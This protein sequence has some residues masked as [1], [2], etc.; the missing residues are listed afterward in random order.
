M[1]LKKILGLETFPLSEIQIYEKLR[2][3]YLQKQTEVVFSSRGKN[4]RVKLN[5]LSPDGLMR[6]YEDYYKSRI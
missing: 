2:E 4:V 1:A 3:A 6:G 5:Q